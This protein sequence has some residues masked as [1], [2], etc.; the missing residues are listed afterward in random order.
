M[1]VHNRR[2]GLL[3][4]LLMDTF[5]KSTPTNRAALLAC[6]VW[7]PHCGPAGHRHCP[8][9]GIS[10]L[11][12]LHHTIFYIWCLLETYFSVTTDWNEWMLMYSI[13][14]VVHLCCTQA[15]WGPGEADS[16]STLFENLNNKKIKIKNAAFKRRPKT[17]N[18]C[19]SETCSISFRS[20]CVIQT[21][22]LYFEERTFVELFVPYSTIYSCCWGQ[23]CSF[24]LN[25]L[26][27]ICMIFW[28]DLCT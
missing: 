6:V 20:F 18:S 12:H 7:S 27:F 2:V 8:F 28:T 17:G 16:S 9:T 11:S 23:C 1:K 22:L 3:S 24:V 26:V 25:L 19:S 21:T 13:P 15:W 5:V 14:T 4:C 10:T